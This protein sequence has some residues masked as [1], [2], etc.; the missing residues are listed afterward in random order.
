MSFNLADSGLFGG[1]YGDFAT[2]DLFSDAAQVRAMLAVEGALAQVQ[3]DLGQ[4]P[5]ESA[6]FIGRF[7]RENT[8]DVEKLAQ[9][10]KV[11]GLAVPGLVAELRR[12]LN[13]SDHAQYVHWGATSQDI[14]DTALMLRLKSMTSVWMRRLDALLAVLADLA[15]THANLPMAARTYGQIATPTSF[16]A[17]VASW[18]QPI[19]RHRA[20]LRVLL[21]DL[22]QVSLGGAAGTLSA[23]G[24]RADEVRAQ[25][26]AELGLGN[27]AMNWHTERDNIA[28]FAGWMAGLAG[29]LGKMGEDISLMAQSGIAEIAL[30]GSGGSSTMPQKKNPVL[31]MVLAALSRH[32]IGLTPLLQGAAIH[33][34]QRDGAAWFTEWLTLPQIC[35]STGRSLSLA[36]E[37]LHHVQPDPLAMTRGL[38]DGRSLI[39]AEEL[40]FLLA[41]I[42]P[43]GDAQKVV[44]KLCAEAIK[45]DISLIRLADRD[46][47]GND[48]SARLTSAALLGQAPRQARAFAHA[49]GKDIPA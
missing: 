39:F 47:P 20:R 25:L 34:Q 27:S 11:D 45:S 4:I 21:P 30:S 10:T 14:V 28:A 24:P 19:L 16:G 33:R 44:K 9:T 35:V 1:L 48:F 13:D 17:I 37:L 46:F 2:S 6:E 38:D 42:L 29:S 40:S 43:R 41:R 18:G 22:L 3:G 26:A 5:R 12:A 15:E 32:V 7:C 23:L 31:A 49:V 36:I 8:L